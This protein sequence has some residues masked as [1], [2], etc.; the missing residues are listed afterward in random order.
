MN[1]NT[2]NF[3]YVFPRSKK[4]ETLILTNKNSIEGA[5]FHTLTVLKHPRLD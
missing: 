3:E 2:E 4:T 5:K 1:S